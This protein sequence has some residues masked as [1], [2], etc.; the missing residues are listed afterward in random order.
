LPGPNRNVFINCPF[1]ADFQSC[2]E[3]LLF[4]ITASGY[5]ARCA[6]EDPDGAN[7]RFDKLRRL[8]K[9]S[10]RSIH[11]LSRIELGANALPRFNMPFELG[12]AMGAKYFGPPARRTNSALIMVREDYVLNAYLSDLGGNDP[13]A[14]NDNPHQVIR[15]VMRYLHTTPEGRVLQGP[16]ISIARFERFK[17]T[18]PAMA[19]DLQRAPD[20][21]DPYHDYPVY[22]GLLTEFLA[23]EQQAARPPRRR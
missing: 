12:L 7:I 9:E 16:Q 4:A 10:P 18:L 15:I 11:D 23:I 17:E 14:H 20:E 19:R 1:D 5:Q 13:R 2:F 8:I 3:A 22:L 21:V 6:L